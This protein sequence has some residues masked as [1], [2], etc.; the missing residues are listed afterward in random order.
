MSTQNVFMGKHEYL[1]GYPSYLQ[2]HILLTSYIGLDM[3]IKTTYF[4]YLSTKIWVFINS[5]EYPQ[6][7]LLWRNKKNTFRLR[8]HLSQSENDAIID[9][10]HFL[11]F[12]TLWANSAD[13][14]LIIFFSF[15]Q[16]I[17]FGISCKLS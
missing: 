10:C 14:K 17:G 9:S 6:H 12:T 3:S 7:I 16:K 1:S 4:S 11:T 5:N 13:D 8:K 15:F 2:L